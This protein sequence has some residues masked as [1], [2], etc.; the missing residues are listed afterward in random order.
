MKKLNPYKWVYNKPRNDLNQKG[1]LPPPN[2][3]NAVQRR[4]RSSGA[5]SAIGLAPGSPRTPPPNGEMTLSLPSTG[6]SALTSE[7]R[8]KG[9]MAP[10]PRPEPAQCPRSGLPRLLVPL[11]I[12]SSKNVHRAVVTGHTDEGRVLIEVDAA[13]RAGSLRFRGGGRSLAHLASPHPGQWCS[14]APQL[15]RPSV[16]RCSRGHTDEAGRQW[17]GLP[18]GGL[19]GPCPHMPLRGEKPRLDAPP[20]SHRAHFTAPAPRN[21]LLRVTQRVSSPV[22]VSCL[23]PSSQFLD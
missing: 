10:T 1:L 12:F 2:A 16:P 22:N 20:E 14:D 23:R 9:R 11:R 17:G 7:T 8:A 6:G 15:G 21:S 18:A 5:S 3:L 4:R 19:C 13:G